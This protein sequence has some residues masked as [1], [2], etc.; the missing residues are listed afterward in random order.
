MIYTQLTQVQRYQIYALKKMEHKPSQI[1][2]CL[3][4]HKATISRE[5]QRNSGLRGYRPKQAH[6]KALERQAQKVNQR[7]TSE[8]WVWVEEKLRLDWSP[9]QVSGWLKEN[10]DAQVSHEWIYQYIYADK[11]AGG[12]LHKHLRCKKKRRKRYGSKDR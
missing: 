7:I 10:S 8:N 9:E 12:N 2:R 4:V 5:L 3:E 6:K 11:R 1:A